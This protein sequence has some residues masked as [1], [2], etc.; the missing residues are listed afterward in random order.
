MRSTS[1]ADDMQGRT[2]AARMLQAAL[3]RGELE[4]LPSRDDPHRWHGLRGIQATY[5]RAAHIGTGG[6]AGRYVAAVGVDR[7]LAAG[8]ESL[9][10]GGLRWLGGDPRV[11]VPTA[12]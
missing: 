6:L 7:R 5:G 2:R 9:G 1:G 4:P 11:P 10:D 3:A 12:G 8:R